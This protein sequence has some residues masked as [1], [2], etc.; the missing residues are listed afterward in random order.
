LI[1]EPA[2][3]MVVTYTDLGSDSE[4]APTISVNHTLDKGLVAKLAEGSPCEIKSN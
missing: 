2:Y 1:K 4:Y 3:G